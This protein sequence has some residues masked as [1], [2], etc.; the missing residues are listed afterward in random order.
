MTY[1]NNLVTGKFRYQNQHDNF[2]SIK[3]WTK[4]NANKIWQYLHRLQVL[5]VMNFQKV[6][7]V[8]SLITNTVKCRC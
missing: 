5:L 7:L 6:N 2:N 1:K 8:A 4:E 3:T